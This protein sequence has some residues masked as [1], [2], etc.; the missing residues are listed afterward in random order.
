MIQDEITFC[1]VCGCR[2]LTAVM[3][4]AGD[5]GVPYCRCCADDDGAPRTR[6]QLVERLMKAAIDEDGLGYF[7][8]LAWAETEVTGTL[9]RPTPVKS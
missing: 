6:S 8:A 7:E 5:A 1:Q 2:L 3:H 9:G 4:A